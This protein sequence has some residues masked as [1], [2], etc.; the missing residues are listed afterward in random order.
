LAADVIAPAEAGMLSDQADAKASAAKV[1]EDGRATA[2]VLEEMITTWQAGG[3]AAR[4]IF[5]MQKL[6]VV[7]A[8][9]VDTI[10]DVQVDKLTILPTGNGRVSDSVRLVEELKAG[11]DVDLPALLKSFVSKEASPMVIE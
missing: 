7:M 10:Q 6:Q 9:L 2:V 11:V 3:S 1:Y 8:S 4:D 5:L